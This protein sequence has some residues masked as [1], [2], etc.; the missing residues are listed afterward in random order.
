MNRITKALGIVLS[1]FLSVSSSDA[2]VGGL[3]K[4]FTDSDFTIVVPGKIDS[5]NRTDVESAA[6]VDLLDKLAGDQ[7]DGNISIDTST[8]DSFVKS[9]DSTD[10]GLAVLFDQN[11]VLK[12][13]QDR[14]IGVVVSPVPDVMAWIAYPDDSGNMMILSD[15]DDN[16]F[17]SALKERSS[18]YNQSVFFPIMDA[19]DIAKI[20][21]AAVQ[22]NDIVSVADASNRYGAKYVVV[23]TINSMDGKDLD[24]NW[25]LYDL[26]AMNL[27]L[28]ESSI[29]G[30]S[31]DIG[32]ILARNLYIQFAK[33]HLEKVHGL[34]GSHA[35]A[36]GRVTLEGSSVGKNKSYVVIA[37]YMSYSDVIS[38]ERQLSKLNGVKRVSLYQTQADQAVYEIDHTIDYTAL[39]NSIA[40]IPGISLP[41]S[42]KPYNFI[43]DETSKQ[44]K[45]EETVVSDEKGNKLTTTKD[46]GIQNASNNQTS[47]KQEGGDTSK[48][49]KNDS[50]K[51]ETVNTSQG[52][53]EGEIQAI[54]ITD[55][56]LIKDT[57]NEKL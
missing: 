47:E 48:E 3:S 23:G 56:S 28:N 21:V 50:Q 42:S 32:K 41:N 20:S 7:V 29:H 26:T 16:G 46:N 33:D 10:H 44:L 51:K 31:F 55:P 35:P 25:K 11:K 13:F 40:K 30:P 57:S 15:T 19:D 18:F 17:I 53:V 36:A 14:Q 37:G 34:Q 6:F 9:I 22:N 1:G 52:E 2:A 39:S 12:F 43:F 54:P 24:L 5:F 45:V 38:L 27:A 4:E 49:V 8:L